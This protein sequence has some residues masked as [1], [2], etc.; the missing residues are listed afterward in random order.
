MASLR[1]LPRLLAGAAL[2]QHT[3]P[4]LGLSTDAGTG[5]WLCPTAAKPPGQDQTSSHAPVLLRGLQ[6]KAERVKLG[7]EASP[8]A[9]G[10]CPAAPGRR[11]CC[12]LW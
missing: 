2:A 1:A 6:N 8:V 5:M 11:K 3:H 10:D 7:K 4:A 9:L 12:T